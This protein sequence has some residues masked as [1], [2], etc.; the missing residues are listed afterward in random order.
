MEEACESSL[1][2]V[3]DVLAHLYLYMHAQLVLHDS[4]RAWQD[5]QIM[6]DT[7]SAMDEESNALQALVTEL[8]EKLVAE[9]K[10]HLRQGTKQKA[11][12]RWGCSSK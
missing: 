6:E 8:T 1:T 7:N 2:Q 4:G 9:S 12:N 11:I 3:I 10:Y 5:I